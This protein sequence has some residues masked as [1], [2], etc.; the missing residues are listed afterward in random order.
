MN[1]EEI[2]L[3]LKKDPVCKTI[4]Y[5]VYSCDNIPTVTRLPA[6]IVCNTDSKSGPGEHWIVIY[7]DREGRGEYFDSFGRE[8][9]E[10]FKSYLNR[11]CISWIYCKKQLQSVVS[12]FCGHY[13]I[14]YCLYRCR[15]VSLI[16]I[17]GLFTRDTGLNDAIV[18]K[19]IYNRKLTK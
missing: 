14:F 7:L 17:E 5:G 16:K 3:Y 2:D 15:D 9:R 18:Y 4:F 19:F 8:P 12:I 10:N 13:C 1:T 6:L 11:H